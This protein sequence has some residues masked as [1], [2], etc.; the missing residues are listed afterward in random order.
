MRSHGKELGL[1]RRL[2]VT[3][4]TIIGGLSVL[5]MLAV[6][7]CNDSEPE[8]TAEST[9]SSPRPAASSTLTPTETATLISTDTDGSDATVG[10]QPFPG[11][12]KLVVSSN[13]SVIGQVDEVSELRTAPRRDNPSSQ[14]AYYEASVKVTQVTFGYRYARVDRH[15][16]VYYVMDDDG[17]IPTTSPPMERGETVL[18][19]LTQDDSLYGPDDANLV[20]HPVIFD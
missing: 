17:R 4:G 8:T 18:L 19:F 7:A 11:L 20:V 9:I 5:L 1:G 3:T 15:L 2:G 14:V 16:S 12:E 6:A 10:E 13:L